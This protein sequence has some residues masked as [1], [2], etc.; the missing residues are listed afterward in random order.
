MSESVR[1]NWKHETDV[2]DGSPLLAS[3]CPE[4]RAVV[5]ESCRM[6]CNGPTRYGWTAAVWWQGEANQMLSSTFHPTVWEAMRTAEAACERATAAIKA[7]SASLDA[8]TQ[9]HG[10]RDGR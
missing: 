2:A 1:R 6:D 5:Y 9:K 10:V 7:V 4:L 8:Y 3:D